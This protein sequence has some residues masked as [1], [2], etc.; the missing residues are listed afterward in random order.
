[1]TDVNML[2]EHV[3]YTNV[4]YT[5]LPNSPLPTSCACST[6]GARTQDSHSWGAWGTLLGG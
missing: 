4:S 2:W 3:G 6:D 1:M 5:N